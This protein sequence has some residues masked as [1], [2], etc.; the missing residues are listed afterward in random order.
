MID[1]ARVV[2]KNVGQVD[3]GESEAGCHEIFAEKIPSP[4][5]RAEGSRKLTGEGKVVGK[6]T[7]KFQACKQWLIG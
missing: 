6:V 5:R 3:M 1:R 7:L 2:N 4:G